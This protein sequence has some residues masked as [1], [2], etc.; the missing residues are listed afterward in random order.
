MVSQVSS[1]SRVWKALVVARVDVTLLLALPLL[2]CCKAKTRACEHARDAV[3]GMLQTDDRMIIDAPD[4]MKDVARERRDR[5][6]ALVGEHFVAKCVELDEAGT[7]C[8]ERID[9]LVAAALAGREKSRSCRESQSDPDARYACVQRV[10]QE[11]LGRVGD[12][13]EIVDGLIK[14]AK[15]E[16]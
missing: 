9:E 2:M 15:K 8:M 7:A 13:A 1:S 11:T 6:A 14:S 10:T 4:D 16:R 12:C 3:V 5:E